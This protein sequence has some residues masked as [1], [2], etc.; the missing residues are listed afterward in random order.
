MSKTVL[1]DR[2]NKF[3]NIKIILINC[4]SNTRIERFEIDIFYNTIKEKIFR[5]KFI[6]ICVRLLH[7]K[8]QKTAKRN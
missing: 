1:I 6:N 4:I 3:S 5:D 7:S 2:N 8:P